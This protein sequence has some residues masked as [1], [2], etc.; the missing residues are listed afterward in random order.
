MVHPTAKKHSSLLKPRVLIIAASRE[1]NGKTV[2]KFGINNMLQ[3]QVKQL[4]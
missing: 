4:Y 2:T 3:N 1:I